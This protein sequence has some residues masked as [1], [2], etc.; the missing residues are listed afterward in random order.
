MLLMVL[1]SDM[2]N[3]QLEICPMNQFDAHIIH[4]YIADLVTSL[5]HRRS[6]RRPNCVCFTIY[7]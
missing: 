4:V 3:G 1:S 5:T 6:T 7:V 2:S